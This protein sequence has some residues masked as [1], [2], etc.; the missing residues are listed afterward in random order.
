MSTYY[1][2]TSG[3]NSNGGSISSP[4]LTLAKGLSVMVAG[5]TLYIRGGTYTETINSNSYTI[6]VGTSF[7]S[8]V[9]IAA[10]PS[11][12]VTLGAGNGPGSTLVN[13]AHSYIRY[14]IFDRLI[15]DGRNRGSFGA[16]IISLYGGPNHL[17]FTNCEIKNSASQGVETFVANGFS[18]DFNEFIDCSIHDNGVDDNLDHGFYISTKNNIIQGCDIY[19]NAAFGVQ[20]YDGAGHRADNNVVRSCRL[21]GNGRG[22]TVLGSGDNIQAYN[23]LIYGNARGIWVSSN[24]PTNVRLLNNTI[25]NNSIA[26]I[27][28]DSASDT[29]VRNNI[30]YSNG[31]TITGSCIADHNLTTNPLF[32]SV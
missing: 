7:S 10:Y 11:E 13:F 29:I 24:S 27:I 16:N 6:P 14:I 25:Y 8:P 30:I 18:S 20:V 12:T 21:H 15:L 26:G 17:R 3:S 2:A 23:N 31:T 19:D 22:G 32:V 5:D 1:I 9:T 4:F 28:V